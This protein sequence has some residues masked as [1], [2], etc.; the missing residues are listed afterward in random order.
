MGQA[1][2]AEVGT[3]THIS[4]RNGLHRFNHATCII[5]LISFAAVTLL[6]IPCQALPHCYVTACMKPT[7]IRNGMHMI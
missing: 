5:E 7:Q 6:C 3:F 2:S 4:H 1:H